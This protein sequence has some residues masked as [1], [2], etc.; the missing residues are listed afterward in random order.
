[1][2]LDRR[3]ELP[4]EC[5]DVNSV[6][7][8]EAT[9]FV[10]EPH[11]PLKGQPVT[12]PLASTSSA[13]H[14]CFVAGHIY[15]VLVPESRIPFV[16]GAEVQ[17][18]VQIRALQRA[19]YKIS[20]LTGDYGQADVVDARGIAV[21]KIPAQG[22]RGLRGSRFFYPRMTDMV[23]SLR[24]VSPDI[25]FTQ[26]ASEQVP[27]AA[28]YA[29]LF[30]KR[31]VFAGASDPDFQRG[32]LPGMPLQHTLMYRWGLRRADAVVVQN[33]VQQRLLQQNFGR[34]GDLIPNG[35]EEPGARDGTFE[36]PVLWAATVKPLKQPELFVQ[37]AKRLPHRRFVMVGGP[38]ITPEAKAYFDG[39]VQAAASAPNLSVLGHVPFAQVGAHFDGVGVFV[40]TSEYEGLPNT[41]MQ[42]WSRGIPSVSFVRPESAPGESGTLACA[43]LEQMINEVERLTSRREEWKQASAACR[44]CFDAHHTMEL[45]IERYRAL[46]SRVLNQ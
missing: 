40:N 38:G 39:I 21:H 31:F 11:S 13:V 42:A 32:P 5:P 16:G 27:S 46:F 34:D 44:R 29:R 24:K 25:V 19:G 18:T 8:G 10:S 35:Y 7:A 33:A 30:G 1:M 2:G 6:R 3:Q 45:A 41:F 15:P 17:Q 14:L 4:I 36:G 37:L 23:Q 9:V 28:V 22:T 26:T 43:D 20:V 12:V